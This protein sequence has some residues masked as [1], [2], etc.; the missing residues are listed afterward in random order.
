MRANCCVKRLRSEQSRTEKYAPVHPAGTFLALHPNIALSPECGI[1]RTTLSAPLSWMLTYVRVRSGVAIRAK[2]QESRLKE[3]LFICLRAVAP[4][5]H[6]ACSFWPHRKFF[7]RGSHTA[8]LCGGPD[9]GA[10][11]ALHPN[12][13]LSDLAFVRASQ[14]TMVLFRRRNYAPL[15]Q[16]C[17]A[18][19]CACSCKSRRAK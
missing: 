7:R 17:T 10:F 5:P 13:A 8:P 6:K 18:G 1:W 19:A 3:R 14:G 4:F 15:S 2:L 16:T 12:I 11:L 9:G